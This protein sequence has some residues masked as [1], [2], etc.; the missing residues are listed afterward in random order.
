MIALQ[1]RNT[2]VLVRRRQLVEQWRERL[3]TF[4]SVN[5]GYIGIIGGGKRRPT[6]HIDI[7]LIQSLERNG[8][9]DDSVG[10]YGHSSS[11]NAAACPP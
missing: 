3:K 2:L 5:D 4:L 7:A 1:S 11:I 8:E 10:N 9:V 6:G